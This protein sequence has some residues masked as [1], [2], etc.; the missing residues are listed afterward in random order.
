VSINTSAKEYIVNNVA[1]SKAFLKP[2]NLVF[3]YANGQSSGATGNVQTLKVSSG[4]VAFYNAT[5]TANIQLWVSKPSTTIMRPGDQIRGWTS[6]SVAYIGATNNGIRNNVT[7]PQ[8]RQLV[9][10]RTD[11]DWSLKAADTSG[12]IASSWTLVEPNENY[13][14][15]TER[16]IHDSS[17]EALYGL[18]TD[19]SLRFKASLQS[20]TAWL[21]PVIDLSSTSS[22]VVG[23]I[24]NNDATNETNARGGNAKSRYITRKATLD[25]DQDAEDLQ[26]RVALYQP[27]STDFK[28]Y[29]KILNGE[30]SDLFDDRPWIEM[31]RTTSTV[32][33][34]DSQNK[35]DFRDVQF[36]L[37][38]SILT[39]SGGTVQYVNSAGVTFSGFKYFSVKIVP[40][41][42]ST[43]IVPRFKQPQVIA[44]QR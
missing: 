43:A 30:D 31:S 10:A 19:G 20:N 21:S 18:G 23:N 9:F 37:P 24:V 42:T 11:I 3:Q 8:A 25:K 36:N 27:A 38:S 13:T 29:A 15:D 14:F 34:S 32:Y 35:N 40:L 1:V 6:N 5:Q 7:M 26:V 33:Y 16:K 39:G 17:Y 28:V 4:R 41:S 44:L 22:I 12:T 2:E